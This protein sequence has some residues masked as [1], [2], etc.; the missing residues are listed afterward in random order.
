MSDTVPKRSETSAD[1]GFGARL[2]AAILRGVRAAAGPF[3]RAYDRGGAFARWA[4]VVLRWLGIAACILALTW[5]KLKSFDRGGPLATLLH[6]ALLALLFVGA[7][8]AFGFDDGTDWA[9]WGLLAY[10]VWCNYVAL[11]RRADWYPSEGFLIVPVFSVLQ[12][13][14]GL[15]LA[16]LVAAGAAAAEP[17]LAFLTFVPDSFGVHRPVQ[18]LVG[19]LVALGLMAV[20]LAWGRSSR[21]E[22]IRMR[23][24]DGAFRPGLPLPAWARL[25][26]IL[27]GAV[28]AALAAGA[29][30]WAL[31]KAEYIGAGMQ[32]L[33]K[34]L[35]HA[36]GDS[37][38]ALFAQMPA[39]LLLLAAAAA[40]P[41]AH[42]A[43]SRGRVANLPVVVSLAGLGL[44][45][46]ATLSAGAGV[47]AR[48]FTVADTAVLFSET[49][50]AVDEWIDGAAEAGTAPA[51]MVAQLQA[52]GHWS[53]RVD[54]R[55]LP[56]L[57]PAL[58]GKLVWR[59]DLACTVDIAAGTL[60][61][62]ERA[63]AATVAGPPDV[64]DEAVQSGG[65]EVG[66]P[67]GLPT[68][69]PIKYCL[70]TSCKGGGETGNLTWLYSSHPSAHDGWQ[71]GMTV[72]V[73]FGR[74][75]GPGGFCTAAG[76]LADGFQG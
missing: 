10:I 11:H 43:L 75:A 14:L 3:G 12:L 36:V 53:G 64:D 72:D 58:R 35:N 7:I 29:A 23:G 37:L 39:L 30:V 51:A 8:L 70:R 76:G 47:N 69:S 50:V 63:A 59:D 55:G 5:L 28:L 27:F 67:R 31:A 44:I 45:I 15:S 56:E 41:V 52:N 40:V 74:I 26:R 19:V 62:A 54:D 32:K 71:Q 24:P 9:F 61:E 16:N 68:M 65:A 38:P 33:A 60:S 34:P 66:A 73:L 57:L 4:D 22:L 48:G 6:A 1:G 46:A 13:A 25:G 20:F 2:D 42:R 21:R 17:G 49:V 18:S